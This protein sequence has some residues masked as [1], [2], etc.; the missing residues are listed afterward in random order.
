VASGFRRTGRGEKSRGGKKREGI[1]SVARAIF[2]LTVPAQSGEK[3]TKH[4]SPTLGKIKKG[5][6]SNQKGGGGGEGGRGGGGGGAGG[7][8]VGFFSY[9]QPS[10]C[11]G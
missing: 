11:G 9:S 6:K 4:C 10:I 7:A 3:R 1:D 8:E 2:H 5:H